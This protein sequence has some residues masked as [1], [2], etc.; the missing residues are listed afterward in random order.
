MQ[1]YY[2]KS[3]LFL[4][5]AKKNIKHNGSNCYTLS[6]YDLLLHNLT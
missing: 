3:Q 1:F 2:L 6:S 4:R 5:D